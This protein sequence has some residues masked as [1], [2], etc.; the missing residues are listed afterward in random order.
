MIR[1][2][3]RSTLFPYTTLFRSFFA[4]ARSD[5]CANESSGIAHRRGWLGRAVFLAWRDSLDPPCADFR[6][7]RRADGSEQ[8]A[9]A[10][11]NMGDCFAPESSRARAC[12]I[13]RSWCAKT[14]LLALRLLEVGTGN[15]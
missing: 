14:F 9:S 10:L 2:P 6:K 7:S 8:S 12:V 15:G 4:A 3:P 5:S 11:P 13:S 1:R